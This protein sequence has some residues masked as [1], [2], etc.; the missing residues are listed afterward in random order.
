MIPII[1][2]KIML[3]EEHNWDIQDPIARIHTSS[4]ALFESLMTLV[5]SFD[6]LLFI[7]EYPIFCICNQEFY[8]FLILSP[9][10]WCIVRCWYKP[11]I[12]NIKMSKKDKRKSAILGA[13]ASP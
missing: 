4:K 1:T 2:P 13:L 5:T 12:G 11:Q 6:H 3:E 9:A 7:L 8:F 10:F